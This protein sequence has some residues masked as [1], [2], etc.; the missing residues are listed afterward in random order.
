MGTGKRVTEGKSARPQSRRASVVKKRER[1]AAEVFIEGARRRNG[2][3][4]ERVDLD[5]ATGIATMYKHIR[6]ERDLAPQEAAIEA[7]EWY[8][9]RNW[10]D[11]EVQSHSESNGYI[12]FVMTGTPPRTEQEIVSMRDYDGSVLYMK[13]QARFDSEVGPAIRGYAYSQEA[14]LNKQY[15]G[16]RVLPATNIYDATAEKQARLDARASGRAA[17]RAGGGH[18][19]H[20]G[21][22]TRGGRFVP[23]HDAKLK[24]DLIREAT[25]EAEAERITRGWTS[26]PEKMA[27]KLAALV[28]RGDE[29]IRERVVAR[30]GLG[31]EELF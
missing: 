19:H 16:A 28:A 2:F 1:E 5:K 6:N 13:V 25:T 12:E 21:E 9:A 18:C 23:G 7:V 31:E 3:S 17:R 11:V 14:C 26:P 30:T 8:E 24:G 29:F 20:C 22:A 10:T 27:P 15:L 4:R